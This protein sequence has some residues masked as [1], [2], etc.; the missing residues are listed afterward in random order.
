MFKAKLM[1][2]LIILDRH[3]FQVKEL[4]APYMPVNKKGTMR[5]VILY[6]YQNYRDDIKLA[7]LA[8]RFYLSVPHISASF[9]LYS[10]DH[11][12]NFLEKIRIS[13]ACS[14]L[15]SSTESVI[16]ICYE[17]GFTSYPTFSRVFR[18]RLHMPPTAYRKLYRK[19]VFGNG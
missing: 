1:E 2:V 11:F 18:E 16:S 13:H 7:T 14:L 6:V 5:D 15:A 4:E 12:H 3:C 9:K 17:V 8:E 19:D 10:G